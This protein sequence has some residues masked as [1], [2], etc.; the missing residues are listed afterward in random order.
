VAPTQLRL[1]NETTEAP[2][3][4]AMR[5]LFEHW[6]FM[7]GKNPRRCALGP[8]RRKVIGKALA[9][10]DEET[11]QLAIEGCASSAYHAGDNDRDTPYNDLE[12]IFRNEKYVERFATMGEQLRTKAANEAERTRAQASAPVPEMDEAQAKVQRDRLRELAQRLRRG[13]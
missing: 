11:L 6:V 4:D 10:Y 5:R 3:P 13:A 8:E 7:M 12:L 1:V 9:L 2:T